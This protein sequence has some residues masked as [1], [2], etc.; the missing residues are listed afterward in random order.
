MRHALV[1]GKN[2]GYIGLKFVPASAPMQGGLMRPC[3]AVDVSF[4]NVWHDLLASRV[5]NLNGSG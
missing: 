2:F 5:S 1:I 3:D 4:Y